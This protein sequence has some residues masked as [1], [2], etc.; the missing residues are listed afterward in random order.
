MVI[1]KNVYGKRILLV[2]DDPLVLELYSRVFRESG[3]DVEVAKDGRQGYEKIT[4]SVPD[5]VI[6]DIRMPF[7]NGVEVLRMMRENEATKNV[8]VLILTNYDYE[9]Y[10]SE[11]SELGVA[12]FL[13]KTAVEPQ[14]VVDFVSDY[15]G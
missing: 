14:T 1:S 12:G 13:A 8:P 10:R 7:L 5:F 11:T 2:D 6:L 3:I 9:D 15:F 4:S